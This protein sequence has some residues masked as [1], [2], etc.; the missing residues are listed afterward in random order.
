MTEEQMRGEC[1]RMRALLDAYDAAE[2][3]S[4]QDDRHKGLRKRLEA[5]E[6]R[7]AD[8]GHD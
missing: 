2:A 4:P 8:A 3:A 7:L 1:E 5:M 6:Q